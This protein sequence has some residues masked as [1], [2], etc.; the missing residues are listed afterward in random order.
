MSAQTR[1]SY[2]YI[3]T[4]PDLR[5]LVTLMRGAK[6]LALDTEADSLHHY[7]EKVCLIQ[8]TL[9]EGN[10][11]IDPLA[12]LE[13]DGFFKIL[14]GKPLILHGADYDLRILHAS[15]GF[16]PE[17]GVFDTMLAAQLLGY[18]QLGLAA[19]VQRYHDVTLTKQNQRFDWSQR[20]LPP[21][22]LEYASDDTYFLPS[23][24]ARL[25]A[26]LDR[27]GRVGWHCEACDALVEVTCRERPEPDPDGVWRIKGSTTLTRKQLGILRKV[28]HWREKAAR[29]ANLPPFKILGN[30]TLLDLAVWADTYPRQ[31]L[32]EGPRLPRNLYGRR[33]SELR[34]AVDK[35]RSLKRADWP[36]FCRKNAHK[37]VEIDMKRFDKLRKACAAA[38]KELDIAP[39]TLA[40]RAALETMVLHEAKTRD[41]IL[42]C[43]NLA[44]WQA[45]LMEKILNR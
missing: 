28:W 13:L 23:L 37:R 26:E 17:K 21:A 33:F 2:T 41:E 3:E 11:I 8:L 22:Q 15:C 18:E 4:D 20:P 44:P 10:Y 36:S 1:T 5:S 42:A 38:A 19:L 25:E 14:A 43:T 29:K 6:R 24:A 34:R 30:N 7:Y 27:L 45:G 39:S 16:R 31:R 35:G 32:E 40:P 12:G 9:D